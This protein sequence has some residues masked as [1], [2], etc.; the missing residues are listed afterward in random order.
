MTQKPPCRI[1]VI[2]A[3]EAPIGVIF[4]RGPSHWVQLIKWYTDTDT[5]ELGHW[6]HGRI[7]E[8]S[9]DLSPNGDLLVYYALKIGR[10][11]PRTHEYTHTWIAISKPPWLTALA[12]WFK[13]DAC[14][15]GGLFQDHQTLW[16][17]HSPQIPQPDK[18]Y[19]PQSLDVILS[20]EVCNDRLISK[21]R[22]ER[23]G[24]NLHQEIKYHEITHGFAT[25]TPEILCKCHPE[26]GVSLL[27]ESSFKKFDI[28]SRYSLEDNKTGER[29]PITGATWA[30]WDQQ[31]R[32]IFVKYG[33][34]FTANLSEFAEIEAIQIADFNNDEPVEITP[35]EY[36]EKW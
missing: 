25:D 33:G 17:N 5:F 14:Y 35:P 19:V 24:W 6:F 15:G 30:D 31:G 32:L 8:K 34:L 10:R 28:V 7:Y 12:L 27:M 3:R 1:Y 13:G 29:Y 21:T 26:Y 22:L 16:I 9:C 20:H 11:S 4:R 23:D 2:L 18:G 36:A